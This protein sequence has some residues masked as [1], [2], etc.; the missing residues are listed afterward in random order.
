MASNPLAMASNQLVLAVSNI[1]EE[2][3][4]TLGLEVKE[5]LYVPGPSCL[6]I[7]GVVQ[8]EHPWIVTRMIQLYTRTPPS[9]SEHSIYIYRFL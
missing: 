3:S 1:L 4:P 7:L 2:R 9:T 8:P 6:E 5:H